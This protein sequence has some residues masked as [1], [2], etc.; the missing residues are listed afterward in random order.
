MKVLTITYGDSVLFE[1][2]VSEMTWTDSPNGVKVE[3][4]TK[5]S[6]GGLLDL[7]AGAS[8]Q[9]TEQQVERGRQEL[10]N[11]KKSVVVS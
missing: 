5:P 10:V 11:E 4:R 8:K 9:K 7:L 2:E 3:G 6:G 1:G